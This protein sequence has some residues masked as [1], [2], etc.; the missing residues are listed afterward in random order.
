MLQ[1]S[2]LRAYIRL[3]D[4]ADGRALAAWLARIVANEALGRRR[5]AARVV[6]LEDHRARIRVGEDGEDD[7][8]IASDPAS[9][10]PDPERLA[11]SGE[12]RR[13]L[14]AAVDALPQE[15]RTVM[16]RVG[17]PVTPSPS[18][19]A[20]APEPAPASS[21]LARPSHLSGDGGSDG[22]IQ[23]VV[24]TAGRRAVAMAGRR[25]SDRALRGKL[26]S[27][28]RPPVARQEHR[29]RFWA[30][31]AAG[32]VERGR[33][34]G[35]RG[36]AAGRVP[37]V[38]RGGR[39]GAVASVA[40]LEAALRAVP[41][42]RRAGGDRAVAGA[43]LGCA[44]GRASPGAGGLDD[45]AGAAAQRGDAGRQPGLPGD[46]RAVARRAGGASAE[47][48]EAGREPGAADVC[49]GP[50]RRCRRRS[51]RGRGAWASRALEGTPARA[52]AE[53]ALGY[54]VEPAADRRAP[55][56]RPPG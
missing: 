55:A 4:L 44:G 19:A 54:G 30:F 37:V 45:L 52:T 7:T 47:A 2:Y 49:A 50:A 41:V 34:D 3:K 51:G 9:D 20:G 36:I 42:V 21:T 53:P 29:R 31:I 48:G 40:V 10:R 15:F 6:S 28:G 26:R 56:A 1:E 17:Q 18:L 16:A 23:A 33:G 22:Q 39:D 11:A 46:H 27:P 24:A 12:L 43:R 38:P 14:E 32:S 13:L 25:R 5:S 8:T 35:G